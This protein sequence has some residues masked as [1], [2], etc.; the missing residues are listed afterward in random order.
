MRIFVSI[1]YLFLKF[2]VFLTL[3]IFYAKCTVINKK[4]LA[5]KNPAII[6]SNHPSTLM[7]PLNVAVEIPK[8]I[9]FLAN[10][11]LF[12]NPILGA[13]LN[14]FCIPVERPKDVNGRGIQNEENFARADSHLASGGGIYIA[15]EGT[16]EVERR[17]RKIR[18]GTARIAL[19]AENKHNF[20]LGITIIPIG[21]NYTAPLEFRSEVL[22]NVGAPIKLSD[23]Q[24]VYNEDP[25]Q[26]AKQLT[27]D[28]QYQVESLVFHTEIEEQD[29]L[30]ADIETILQSEKPLSPQDTFVRTQQVLQQIKSLSETERKGF[31]SA[32]SSYFELLKKEKINDLAVF[33]FLKN[34]PSFLNVLK[35][36]FGL[37]LFLYG[38]INNFVAFFIPGFLARK[39][40]VFHG[41]KPTIMVMSGLIILPLAFYL[42]TKL[43]S[44]FID[45][46]YI[47]WIYLLTLLPMGWIAWQ[48]RKL[49]LQYFKNSK[50]KKML[51]TT[52]EL[53]EDLKTKREIFLSKINANLEL[54]PAFTLCALCLLCVFCVP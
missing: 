30:L 9:S 31:I 19:S 5:F 38:W 28:L 32:A 35:I 40:K 24:E 7:D 49:A 25:F 43:V 33:N 26:A 42:Q 44:H 13:I 39:I 54:A 12:K 23:Y 20:N 17:I 18:T 51:A 14:M 37:P 16:S 1:I 11:G 48:Y 6:V 47:G 53:F 21:L 46:P 8:Q 4:R 10:A 50:V 3:R 2:T 27:A 41:Y 45:I 15:A 22:V 36:I 34:R 52:P 29:Q